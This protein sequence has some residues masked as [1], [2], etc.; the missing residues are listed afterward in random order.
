MGTQSAQKRLE[1][2]KLYL[3]CDAL[4][5]G[6]SVDE[7]VEAALRGGVDIVQ[8]R[9]KERTDAQL[10]QP[11][12]TIRKLCNDHEALF[13][14]NDYPDLA[15]KFDADGV[16]LGQEDM[17]VAQARMIVG[18]ERLIGLSTHTSMQVDDA[19]A[20]GADYIG[21]GPVYAT[22]TKEGRTAVGVELVQY[23]SQNAR[24]PFFA[25]GGIDTHNAPVV[26]AAGAKRIAVVRAIA[27]SDDPLQAASELR[28]LLED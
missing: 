10:A 8:L 22:P 11:A 14:V 15:V 7:V 2:A 1:T 5:G 28:K 27:K 18:P 16:H 4:P 17:S 21:V 24:L 26:S 25:I 6:R 23:A 13:I 20:S 9:D 3:V 19:N 12:E